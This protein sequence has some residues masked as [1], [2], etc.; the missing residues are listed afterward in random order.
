MRK[1]FS[2]ECVNF[3]FTA[4]EVSSFEDDSFKTTFSF[5]LPPTTTT[6]TPIGGN[7]EGMMRILISFFVWLYR[8]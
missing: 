6:T 4:N 7:E 5:R 2:K 1:L 3:S 8:N